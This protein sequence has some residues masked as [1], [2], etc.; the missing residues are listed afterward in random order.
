MNFS[1]LKMRGKLLSTLI[2]AI[3]VLCM[4]SGYSVYL[5]LR[6]T[7]MVQE[8]M[9]T[10]SEFITKTTDMERA[11]YAVEVDAN[12]IILF[13]GDKEFI[14]ST[15]AEADEQLNVLIQFL[16]E[17]RIDA[18]EQPEE[19][20]LTA[21][22]AELTRQVVAN[23]QKNLTTMYNAVAR[24]DLERA[25]A[26]LA[27]SM[28]NAAD[29]VMESLRICAT[30]SVEATNLTAKEIADSSKT[31]MFVF[32]FLALFGMAVIVTVSIV[33]SNLIA[34]QLDLVSA[35]A[36]AIADGNL[37]VSVRSNRK[38]EI[39]ELFNSLDAIAQTFAALDMEVS[40]VYD[41][42]E[43]KG[44]PEARLDEALF[45]NDIKH[46]ANRF[47]CLIDSQ[48]DDMLGL[49]SFL[50][51]YSAGDFSVTVKQYPGKK[52]MLND[53]AD[54][55]G[56]KLQRV[57]DDVTNLIYT[58][59]SEGRLDKRI[60]TSSYQ[61][62]W[63][64]MA[65]G[66]NALLDGIINPIEEV[67][68]VLSAMAEGRLDVTVESDYKGEFLKMKNAANTTL[69]IMADYIKEITR[70][71][72][73]M[74]Q[75]NLDV[76]LEKNFIGDFKS[77]HTSLQTIIR[78]FNQI[79]RE[80]NSSA[81]Q[82][83]SGAKMI[84]QS[85][86]ALAQ[87]ATEQAASVEELTVTLSGINEQTIQN[88]E[89]ARNASFLASSARENAEEGNRDMKEMLVA[90]KAIS[91]ASQNISKI[92]RVI[93]DI[94]FQ[95]N[96]LALNAAVEAARA[97]EHGKGFT[98]VAEQVRILSAR[99]KEAARQTAT[100]IES[101]VAKVGQGMKIAAETA[102]MLDKIVTQVSD[103]SGLVEKVSASSG[104][105][106]EAISQIS[107]GITQISYVTQTNT[108]TSEETAASSQELQSQAEVFKNMVMHFRLKEISINGMEELSMESS[109]LQETFM[110]VARR[111]KNS[112]KNTAA[113]SASPQ[114]AAPSAAASPVTEN[115]TPA[116]KTEPAPAQRPIS[117]SRPLP[118]QDGK[119]V[120][121]RSDF[122]KY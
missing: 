42:V 96:L 24:G 16:Q 78:T 101:T 58:A 35:N 85:S 59:A 3:A 38:D 44:D 92:I 111:R 15:Y 27:G 122:G 23:Y 9:L 40:R 30:S 52:A 67:I 39:G 72:D 113:P 103:I 55:F 116:T 14:D 64:H 83:S 102:G 106:A 109:S 33:T 62:D 46:I 71:L 53:A 77:I 18:Q 100:L 8:D 82:V 121:S 21:E 17:L 70:V 75:E 47:N 22:Q 51:G 13:A 88:A 10:R 93:D 56:R 1:N 107:D 19:A 36:K 25:S 112:Q 2:G 43:R 73:A 84:S 60:D 95:T 45:Q 99:S 89:S 87:G 26:L 54:D 20:V 31:S 69:V 81:E 98:V 94:A 115:A 7:K 105:Q 90:M 12:N 120:Y 86:M 37:K 66:I 91:D 63:Q 49:I 28:L 110:S 48:H 118:A 117:I 50:N 34:K 6:T 57:R 76:S 79:L 108:A 29:A 5:S 114:D 119:A 80:V 97:G 61:G 11:F 68:A 41:T 74:S 65:D 32:I 4:I 104:A